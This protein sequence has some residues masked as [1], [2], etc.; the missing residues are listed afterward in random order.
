MGPDVESERT[1]K[2]ERAASALDDGLAVFPLPHFLRGN[3]MDADD[4]AEIAKLN[5][6]V[7]AFAAE[8]KLRL[9]QKHMDGYRGWESMGR[10]ELGPRFREGAAFAAASGSKERLV[11][12]ANLAMM[13]HRHDG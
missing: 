10:V 9:L 13:I 2:P 11:D 12:V 1:T 3:V 7:D 4:A 8:M 5:A 6:A